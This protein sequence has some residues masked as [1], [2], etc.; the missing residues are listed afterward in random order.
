MT[1]MS[2]F[3]GS[4]EEVIFKKCLKKIST[5]KFVSADPKNTGDN[6]PALTASKSKASLILF[7][8]YLSLTSASL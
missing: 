1:P 4:G 2:A 8:K 5:P 6:C 7:S 3:L